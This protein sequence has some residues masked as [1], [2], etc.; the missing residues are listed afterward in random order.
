MT[1]FIVVRTERHPTTKDGHRAYAFLVEADTECQAVEATEDPDS[2][3]HYLP[4][5]LVACAHGIV[6]DI[7]IGQAFSRAV[8]ESAPSV[9]LL[10][11]G[12]APDVDEYGYVVVPEGS[13]PFE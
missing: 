11:G 4:D 8:V 7:P 10:R 6:Q 9:R 3:Y 13:L 1:Q 12:E 5:A 2:G